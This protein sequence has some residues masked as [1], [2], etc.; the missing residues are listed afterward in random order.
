MAVCPFMT[1]DGSDAL[2]LAP[3]VNSCALY[4]KGHCAINVLAQK[5][6]ADHRAQAEQKAAKSEQP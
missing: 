6:L 4:I 3:C 2:H 1:K 5:A